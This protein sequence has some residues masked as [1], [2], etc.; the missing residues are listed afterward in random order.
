MFVIVD[1]AHAERQEGQF[2]TQ[3][4]AIVELQRRAAIPWNEKPNRAPLHELADLR[5]SIRTGG[6]RRHHVAMER[7]ITKF[8]TQNLSCRRALG[9][10][11]ALSRV[12]A[13]DGRLRI[14]LSG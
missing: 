11:G 4:Q 9:H 6:V 10:A 14:L 12:P 3:P 5:S 1:E 13:L 8:D 7:A 2:Q